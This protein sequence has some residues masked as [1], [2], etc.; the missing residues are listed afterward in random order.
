MQ[1]T[2]ENVYKKLDAS[3]PSER[4]PV[5]FIGHGSPMN[6]IA[7]SPYGTSWKELGTHLPKPRAIVCMSAHWLT[8]G[9]QITSVQNPEIINDFYGFPSELYQVAY[10]A[11]GSPEIA[12]EIASLAPAYI[13]EN[14]TYG[15]D[16][17]TWTVLKHLFPEANIP[18]LQMSIDIT[19]DRNTQ[20]TLFQNLRSLREQGILFIGSG[21]IVHNLREIQMTGPHEWAVTFD[22]L[23][24]KLIRERDVEALLKIE[25]HTPLANLAIPTDEH[26]RPMI[27]ALALTYDT[28]EIAFFNEHIDL[29][30][31]S[32]RSFI[33]L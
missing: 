6:V 16:H 15:L 32:M 20:Y 8:E 3:S 29:G 2:L 24:E 19:R 1:P 13:T 7:D 4:M 10:P 22:A 12:R 31:I 5:L 33:T 18:V 23:S 17:G 27:N 30:S 26:Y 25:T 28:E 21:N 11:H 9:T 14:Q